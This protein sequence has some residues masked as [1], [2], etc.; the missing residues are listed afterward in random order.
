MDSEP[1]I[2]NSEDILRGDGIGLANPVE[3]FEQKP[4]ASPVT[5]THV[6]VDGERDE[7]VTVLSAAAGASSEAP[8]SSGIPSAMTQ[9]NQWS[10]KTTAQ[11]GGRPPEE[12]GH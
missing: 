3:A 10:E 12:F 2:Q 6:I 1:A 9:H 4:S 5:H 8:A 7:E 11:S